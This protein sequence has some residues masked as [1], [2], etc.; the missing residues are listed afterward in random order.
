MAS[1]SEREKIGLVLTHPASV[2]NVMVKYTK[3]MGGKSR[4]KKRKGVEKRKKKKSDKFEKMSGNYLT[5]CRIMSTLW[6]L[7][8]DWCG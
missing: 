3:S 4:I 6:Y 8:G 1:E 7:C 2:W 5:R